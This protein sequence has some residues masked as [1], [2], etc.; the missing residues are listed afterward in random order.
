MFDGAHHR[1]MKAIA[2]TAFD[3]AAIASYLP[4]L[5]R[6]IESTLARLSKV[7]E[8]SAVEEMRRLA[9]ESICQ[10]LIGLSPGPDTD[11]MRRDYALVLTGVLSIPVP[12]P[13]TAFATARKARD[14]LLTRIRRVIAE[15]RAQPTSDGLSRMLQ[16]KAEDGRMLTDVEA[17]LEVHHV[18]IAGFIVYA[19][20]AEVLRR[21]A[22]SPELCDRCRAEVR[23]H[24][25]EGPL[26]MEALSKLRVCTN[27]VFEAKRCVPLV[28]LAFG[29]AQRTFQCGG[30][31]VPAGWTV[32]LALSLIHKDPTIYKDPTRFDPDRFSPERAEH[33]K[34]PMAF[35]PQGAEPPTGH[36]CLGLEYSTFASVA[37]AALLIRGYEWKLPPQ[38]LEYDWTAVPPRNRDGM[39]VVLRECAV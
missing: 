21:L 25:P 38:D 34:H 27:V 3:H 17:A 15:R 7:P 5:Q 28:P 2:L 23:E 4:E 1:G 30:F 10:N 14:R 18:V 20:L 29:R 37:F 9:I 8:F 35:I 33:K 19:L 13:G 26:T 24:V 32:Y 39:R 36:R 16:G 12:L 11:E 22:E 6:L 31:E